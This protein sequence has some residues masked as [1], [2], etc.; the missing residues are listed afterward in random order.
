MIRADDVDHAP[1][2]A[3]QRA[4]AV[5]VA[6]AAPLSSSKCA[7]ALFDVK[8]SRSAVVQTQVGNKNREED[9]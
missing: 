9:S 8:R 1:V 3:G 5:A 4:V 2:E 6:M 7:A